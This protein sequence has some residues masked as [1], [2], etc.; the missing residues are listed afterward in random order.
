M[1]I[2]EKRIHFFT[3][4][5]TILSLLVLAGAVVAIFRFAKGLGATTNLSDKFPWGLWIGVDVLSGVALAAGGFTIACVVYIFNLKKYYPILRPSILTAFLG[6]LMVIVALLFDLGRPYRIWHPMLMWQHH[7]VMFEVA[8]CVMLYTTVLA[9]EFSPVVFEKFK[10]E[11]PLKIIR[12]ITIPLVIAGI[13]LSTLHQSSLGSLYLIVPNKLHA[14]WWTPLLPV[15]FFISAVMV[16]LAMVIF[17]SFVSS[18]VFKHALKMD[19]ISG[20]AKV[21][22]FALLVYLV[23]KILDISIRGALPSVFAGS[24][25]GNMFLVEII[26]GVIL[27]IILLSL[28]GVRKNIYGVF[29]SSAMVIIG[30][31][32]NR[33]NV[34]IIGM[35]RESRTVYFPAWSEFALTI[36]II[37][38]GMLVFKFAVKYFDIFHS[39]KEVL[40]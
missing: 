30:L 35:L 37:A 13:I 2:G 26:I 22:V 17:E 9:L 18:R 11:V 12:A 33:M 20:L 10:M 36:A 7:S 15:M 24:M 25:E 34:S 40:A 1:N 23:L 29:I 16:G 6:Y 8:W 5:T 3:L 38:G 28:P 21:E 4:R 31:I 19:I 39:E 14:I 32:L 27:P